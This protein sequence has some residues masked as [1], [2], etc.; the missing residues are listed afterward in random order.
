[1]MNWVPSCDKIVRKGDTDM[2][3]FKKAL[4]DSIP[5]MMGYLVV[6]IAYGIYA[7][8][9]GIS[10]LE[11]IAMDFAIYAGS[12]QFVTVRLLNH[13]P[14]FLTVVLLTLLVN[15]RHLFYGLPLISEYKEAKGVKA[16]L[17]Y[18]LTD[19]TFALTQQK[20]NL[21]KKDKIRYYFLITLLDQSYWVLGSILGVVIFRYIP[22]S[23]NG[24]EFAMTALFGV[25]FLEAMR[26]KTVR[27]D[28]YVALA[29]CGAS[30]ILFPKDYFVVIALIA[31]SFYI[32]VFKGGKIHE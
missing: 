29:L 32:I 26:E 4:I 13:A 24:V 27:F 5:V 28:G 21:D 8:D 22:F 7:S 15:F 18:A 12:M 10:A 6:G 11:T 2:K 9:A 25:L 16:Y 3:I 1:M 23:T 17:I 31:I 30:L 19:E 14:A 20:L